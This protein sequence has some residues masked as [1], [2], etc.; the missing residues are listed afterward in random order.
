MP[1]HGKNVNVALCGTFVFGTKSWNPKFANLKRRVWAFDD[2]MVWKRPLRARWRRL[3]GVEST[4]DGRLRVRV[5]INEAAARC[6]PPLP[7]KVER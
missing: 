6:L 3:V 4:S 2:T 7:K 5:C 1:D